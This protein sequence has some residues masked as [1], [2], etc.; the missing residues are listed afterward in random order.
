[1]SST[2]HVNHEAITRNRAAKLA[3][4]KSRHEQAR[5][6]RRSIAE[7]RNTFSKEEDRRKNRKFN[8]LERVM[9]KKLTNSQARELK[10]R[11]IRAD[12]PNRRL[13]GKYNNRP[14]ILED[15]RA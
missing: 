5:G 4:R 7:N 2:E 12:N 3:R 10:L 6:I 11:M 14:R 13:I 15:L 9:G 1:M 8:F